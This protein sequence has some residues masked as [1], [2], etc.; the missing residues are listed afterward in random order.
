MRVVPYTRRRG[1]RHRQVCTRVDSEGPEKTLLL[2]LYPAR[3]SNP[4]SSDLNSDA[5]TTELYIRPL[6]TPPPPP[7]P[8][9]LFSPQRTPVD[10]PVQLRLSSPEIR[11]E[12][13]NTRNTHANLRLKVKQKPTRNPK[14]R[15]SSRGGHCNSVYCQK[16]EQKIDAVSVETIHRVNSRG[17]RMSVGVMDIPVVVYSDRGQEVLIETWT[18]SQVRGGGGGG[19]WTIVTFLF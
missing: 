16:I 4:G 15:T 13:E 17:R 18:F 19:G 10:P 12:N 8:P 6:P 3:G 1:V 2:T 11:T 7:T 9:P 5:L 14:K